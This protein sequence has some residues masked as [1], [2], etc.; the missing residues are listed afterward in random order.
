MTKEFILKTGDGSKIELTLVGQEI[1][2][3]TSGSTRRSPGGI[4]GQSVLIH[5]SIL[6]D[7]VDQQINTVNVRLVLM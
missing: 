7:E 3:V 2:G 5:N 4:T 6:H 1:N